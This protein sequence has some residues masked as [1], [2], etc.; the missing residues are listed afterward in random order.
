MNYSF[1]LSVIN[2]HLISGSTLLVTSKSIMQ[3]E[4]WE[5]MKTKNATSISG[6]PYTFE[7]LKKLGFLDMKL[8]H[9]KTITQAGGK[10]KK[11]LVKEFSE[12]CKNNGKEFFVMYGQTEATARMSYLPPKNILD[13]LESIGIPI[14]GGSFEIINS[15]GDLVIENNIVGELVY[16]GPNVSMGY[17]SCFEDLIEDDI[18]K[19]VLLTGDLATRDNE[20]FYYIVGRKNRFIKVFGNRINLDEI[21][22]LL[23]DTTNNVVCTGEENMIKIFVTDPG[24]DD[25]IKKVLREKM[26]INQ[27][28][29]KI[30]F[31][32]SIPK[33]KSGKVMYSKLN[34]YES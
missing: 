8:P 13:K 19:G 3:K 29:F 24:Y 5:F 22:N 10:L 25:H 16:K 14:P 15:F 18:N 34:E 31:I 32:E 7:I 23:S 30:N 20:G 2:S 6:V 27:T 11:N 33:N 9:L 26:G 12:Y 4:F 21:E 1:G 28:A 17:A